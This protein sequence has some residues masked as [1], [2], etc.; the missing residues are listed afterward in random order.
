[1]RTDPSRLLDL[2]RTELLTLARER[3]TQQAATIYDSEALKVVVDVIRTHTE[4]MGTE[5][6]AYMA[7]RGAE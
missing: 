1:M 4:N 2:P 6:L 7:M 5:E 3:L